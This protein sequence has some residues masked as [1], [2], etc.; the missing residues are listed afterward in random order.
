MNILKLLNCTLCVN[1]TGCEL[2]LKL[3]K[4]FFHLREKKCFSLGI[5]IKLSDG[6]WSYSGI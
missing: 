2:Y 3:Y 5:Y 4:S 1:C 6:P